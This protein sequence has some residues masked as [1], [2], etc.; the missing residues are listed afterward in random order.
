MAIRSTETPTNYKTNSSPQIDSPVQLH[1][2]SNAEFSP[3]LDPKRQPFYH[4]LKAITREERRHLILSF[5][6]SQEPVTHRQLADTGLSATFTTAAPGS[7]VWRLIRTH[8]PGYI[9]SDTSA[10]RGKE[11][12]QLTEGGIQLRN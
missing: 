9:S 7:E 6:D 8:F 4:A 1:L 2:V 3:L 10:K 12:H 5:P 11:T